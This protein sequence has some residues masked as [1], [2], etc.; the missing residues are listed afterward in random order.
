MTIYQE[1]KLPKPLLLSFLCFLAGIS[2]ILVPLFVCDT[3]CKLRYFPTPSRN[4]FKG[5]LVAF[6]GFIPLLS[7]SACFFNSSALSTASYNN[8]YLHH[9][10]SKSFFNQC[11]FKHGLL[12]D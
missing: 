12:K 8:K 6:F 1:S 5:C 9:N 4:I 11:C 10:E 2:C 7:A 3:S